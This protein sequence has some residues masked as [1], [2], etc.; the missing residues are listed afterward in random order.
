MAITVCL[1]KHIELTTV[2]NGRMYTGRV[3]NEGLE[4]PYGE[5]Q[6]TSDPTERRQYFC[7]NCNTLFDGKDSFEG[8]KKHFG[9]V[10]DNDADGV[11]A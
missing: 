9:T 1:L 7:T 6:F 11:I 4:L 10:I 2:M 8:V 5:W 3:D